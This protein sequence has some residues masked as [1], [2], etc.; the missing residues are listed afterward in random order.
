MRL[1]AVSYLNARPLVLGFE[2]GL[3]RDRVELSLGPPAALAD[4]MAAG[5]LDVALLPVAELARMPELEICPGLAIGS[6][7][8]TL[9]VLLASRVPLVEIR[10]VALDPESRT[11]NALVR[12]LFARAWGG[13]PRFSVGPRSL[14]TALAQ[15]DAVVR[16]GDKAL[17]EPLPAGVEGHDLGAAWT[18]RFRLPFVYAVWACR[19]GTLDRGLYRALHASYRAG[20]A[21]LE[22]IAADFEYDGRRE[23]ALASRYLAHHLRYRLGALEVRGLR[24]FLEEAAACGA[25][26]AAP[27]LRF[28]LPRGSAC[29]QATAGT[30]EVRA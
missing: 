17:C 1:G 29:H 9:S 27:A 21:Q 5:E 13:A 16:I 12:V 10:S 15:H 11:S 4:R 28:A 20:A 24:T 23:T 30:T 25:I 2:R 18:T 3:H 26:A 8:P 7:G 6:F 19:P 22:R 14:E